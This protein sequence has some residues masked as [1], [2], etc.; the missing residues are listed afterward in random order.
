M[1]LSKLAVAAAVAGL[2]ATGGAGTALAA[3]A[4]PTPVP[5]AFTVPVD[6]YDH[7]P[8]DNDHGRGW[9]GDRRRNGGWDGHAWRWWHDRGISADLCQRGRGHVDWRHHRCQGGRFNDFRVG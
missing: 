8:R 2:V 9:N 4:D 6:R 5:A 3:P 1:L 7:G